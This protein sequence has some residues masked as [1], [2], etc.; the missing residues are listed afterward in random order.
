MVALDLL[1]RTSVECTN[2][3]HHFRDAFLIINERHRPLADQL[4]M[5]QLRSVVLPI[6]QTDLSIDVFVDVLL[7]ELVA[8][9]HDLAVR[10]VLERVHVVRPYNA[11]GTQVA[12]LRPLLCNRLVTGVLRQL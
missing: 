8:W 9:N 1:M 10:V 2:Y 4:V 7:L 11:H 6:V 3:F 5:Q 12:L